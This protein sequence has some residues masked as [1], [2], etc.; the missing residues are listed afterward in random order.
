MRLN[1]LALVLTFG[2]ASQGCLA[3]TE[4]AQ[5]AAKSN[6]IP[7]NIIMV[8]ADG[9]GPAYTTAYRNFV[10]DPSTDHIEKVVFDEML[11]GNAATNPAKVSGYVTD[12][13]ASATALATGVKS[14]NGA[15]GV[16]VNKKPLPTVLHKAKEK[17]MKTGLAVTSQINHATPASYMVANESR[18]NYDAIANSFFDDRIGDKFLAD[19]MLGG[20]TKHFV[21]KDRDVRKEFADHG[22]AIATSYEELANLPKDKPILGLFAPLGLLPALDDTNRE[23]LSFLTQHAVERLEN[24]NG[25]FLLVEASQVDWA[26]HGND[27]ASAMA[28]MHDLAT[29]ME[30]LKAYVEKH[31]DTLV[32]LTADHSTGGLSIGANGQYAWNPEFIS[33]MKAS[34]GKIA[35]QLAQQQSPL[36]YLE[37][38]LG[39]TLSAEDK[40]VLEKLVAEKDVDTVTSQIKAFLDNKT[41]TGWTTS[42]HTGDDVEVFA[43]GAGYQGFTGQID[44]TDIAKKIFHLLDN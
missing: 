32:V 8:V 39:F 25:F 10:D 15:I 31:P 30:Y 9:M 44:N 21:R 24:P 35:K 16:D 6:T 3:T 14:Y 17:G 33:N 38:Q 43:F 36:L 18:H 23:R 7:K 22:Y 11:V 20:G 4:S 40:K 27:I 29:T 41:N 37:E 13:A 26:G 42:G 34:V 5:S 1:S 12:S 19:V 2:L 28:E